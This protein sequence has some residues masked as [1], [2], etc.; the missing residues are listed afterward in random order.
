MSFFEKIS[1]KWN[2]FSKKMQPVRQAGKT[3][4]SYIY[5][6]RSVFLAIPVAIGAVWL[7]I[8]NASKLPDQVGINLLADGTYSMMVPKGLA[9]LCPL[10]ITALC[11]LL[12]ICSRRTLYPWLISL[13]SLVLPFLI[14]ITNIFP[15]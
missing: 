8:M 14:L 3:A 9:I 15:A 2:T 12:V 5:R 10:A 13:F 7:A 4:C 6:M 11:L 1:D